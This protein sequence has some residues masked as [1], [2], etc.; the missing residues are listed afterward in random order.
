MSDALLVQRQEANESAEQCNGSGPA[1]VDSVALMTLT[2]HHASVLDDAVSLLIHHV[3]RQSSIHCDEKRKIKRLLR[4][5]VPTLFFMPPGELSD[6]EDDD[7]DD[8]ADKGI[9]F[10]L[11]LLEM[12][13]SLYINLYII[14]TGGWWR[15][16]L[17]SQASK[18]TQSL[19]SCASDSTSVD[20]CAWL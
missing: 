15:W 8:D 9:V 4:Q 11:Q 3:K 13:T 14:R 6:D 20:H 5:F 17:V 1:A 12:C 16:A 7:D 19:P 10:T 2:V 18:S